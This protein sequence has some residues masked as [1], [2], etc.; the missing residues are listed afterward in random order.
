MYV[1]MKTESTMKQWFSRGEEVSFGSLLLADFDARTHII[2]ATHTPVCLNEEDQGETD[3]SSSLDR[4]GGKWQTP[5]V[6]WHRGGWA[7]ASGRDVR[8]PGWHG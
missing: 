4:A 6:R 7:R 1:H 3:Q 2:C 8:G 5:A